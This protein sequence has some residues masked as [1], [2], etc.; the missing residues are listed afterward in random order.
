M[1]RRKLIGLTGMA[2]LGLPRGSHAQSGSLPVVGIMLVRSDDD[3]AR[4]RV[5]EIRKGLQQAGLVEGTHYSL[6]V[7]FANGDLSRWPSIAQELGALNPKTIVL[8]GYGANIVRGVL[9]KMPLVITAFAVD[10]IKAGYA[11]SYAQPGGMI[12]GNVMNALGGEESV[13]QK[14]ISLLK[15]LVPD[16]TRLGMI[17]VEGG[18]VGDI[19][20]DGLQKVAPQ[21]GFDLMPYSVRNLDELQGAF[22]SG[23]RDNVGAFY[24]AGDTLLSNNMPRVMPLAQAS[25]KPTVGSN[26]EWARAGLLMSYST[27]LLDGFRRAGIYAARIVTGTNPGDLPIEQATKF[28]FVINQKAARSL[29]IAISPMT[30]ALA[31]EVVE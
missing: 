17:Y 6:A 25:G 10:P 15:Q 28:L 21:L 7:R 29:G 22:A 5:A 30:L 26:P 8:V 3:S 14:R 20:K 24:I 16:L 13:A 31:D 4:Q 2:A 11:K 27:D 1:R 18:F 19:E 12:T 9:P 23:L